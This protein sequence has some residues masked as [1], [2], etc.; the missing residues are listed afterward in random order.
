MWMPGQTAEQRTLQ[1]QGWIDPING[2]PSNGYM[3]WYIDTI[4]TYVVLPKCFK[5]FNMPLHD[6]DLSHSI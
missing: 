6:R 3:L 1:I 4:D 5:S 2:W